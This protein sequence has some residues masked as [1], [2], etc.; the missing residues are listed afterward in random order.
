MIWAKLKKMRFLYRLLMISGI[1]L[2]IQLLPFFYYLYSRPDISFVLIIGMAVVVFANIALYL[3]V[4]RF[5]RPLMKN[6]YNLKRLSEGDFSAPILQTKET[7]EQVLLTSAMKNFKD[8]FFQIEEQLLNQTHHTENQKT[9]YDQ[10]LGQFTQDLYDYIESVIQQVITSAINMQSAAGEI[11]N[12]STDL[13]ENVNQVTGAAHN[14]G[15]SVEVVTTAAQDL[16]QEINSIATTIAQAKLVTEQTVNAGQE[17]EALTQKLT[18]GA[19][20][21]DRLVDVIRDIAKQTNL[22]AMNATIEA[23]HA[24]EAGKGFSIVAS[25]VK[26][27]A[28]EAGQATDVIFEQNQVFRE[29]VKEVGGTIQQLEDI[30]QQLRTSTDSV[31]KTLEMQQSAVQEITQSSTESANFVKDVGVRIE[32]LLNLASNANSLAINIDEVSS[33]LLDG[34]SRLSGKIDEHRNLA[35]IRDLNQAA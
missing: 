1:A 12:I 8:R 20:E 5:L 28:S 25:E 19:A 22:L 9:D 4:W 15:A 33:G 7:P 10:K 26:T 27:L 11:K 2:T 18:T 24:G 21:I 30:C 14:A 29:V 34:V 23:V 16:N 3:L 17:N 13:K 31:T 35:H 6:I 32:N